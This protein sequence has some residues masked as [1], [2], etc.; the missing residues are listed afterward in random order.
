PFSDQYPHMSVYNYAEN[1]P[2]GSI[3]L[4][5]HQR[6][7]VMQPDKNGIVTP[8][9]TIGST[10]YQGRNVTRPPQYHGSQPSIGPAQQTSLDPVA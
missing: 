6:V 1:E 2:M 4:W 5:G 8:T 10:T 9:F 3:D 7:Y